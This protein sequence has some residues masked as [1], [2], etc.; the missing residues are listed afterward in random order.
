MTKAR[1]RERK[2]KRRALDYNPQAN[3]LRVIR[4]VEKREQEAERTSAHCGSLRNWKHEEGSASQF[5][6]AANLSPAIIDKTEIVESDQ[7]A[8]VALVW[9]DDSK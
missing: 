9:C 6:A 1:Q 4:L 8:T 7:L 3:L 2:K 5:D